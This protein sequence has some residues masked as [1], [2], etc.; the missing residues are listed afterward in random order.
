MPGMVSGVR[1]V[2]ASLGLPPERTY[3]NF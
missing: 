2:L 1:E 3:L